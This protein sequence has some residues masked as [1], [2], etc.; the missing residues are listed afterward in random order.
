MVVF[1]IQDYKDKVHAVCDT[2]KNA[3]QTL[4][5]T[6]S[7][8]GKVNIS[9]REVNPGVTYCDCPDGK[10][11]WICEHKVEGITHI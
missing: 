5:E 6:Y 10:E 8:I 3:E 4:R 9:D 11:F 7:K 2:K 1:I